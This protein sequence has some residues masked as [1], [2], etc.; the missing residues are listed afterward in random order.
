M[1]FV[2]LRH[3]L[4][5]IIGRLVHHF[6]QVREKS[7]YSEVTALDDELLKFI[8]N[9]PPHYALIPDTSL[10]ETHPFIPIHRF[11]LITEI[12][13]V[14]ISLH[15][16]YLLKRLNSERFSR[17]RVAC[18]ESAL[19]DYEIRQAFKISVPK[20][21]RDS[22]S[23]AYREF[24]TAMISGFYFILEPKGRYSDRMHAILDGF[25][26][27]HEGMHELDE[28]TRRELKTIEFLRAKASEVESLVE[29]R[30]PVPMDSG[31]PEHQ[32]QLLLGFQ[33]STS[34]AKVYSPLFNIGASESTP[35]SP[36]ILAPCQHT[37]Q[38]PTFQRLQAQDHANSPTNSSSP[39]AEEENAAQSLLNHWVEAISNA[40][41]DAPNEAPWV[42]PGGDFPP[43]MAGAN[44]TATPDLRLLTGL[45]GSDWS[46]WETLVSQIPRGQ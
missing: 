28:T 41:V 19:K 29:S 16:P 1:T 5:S 36:S 11:L 34:P 4:A 12:I 15:R 39:Q 24:Q 14:R 37:A 32:V 45:D 13:F 21:T 20:E 10:D 38:S 25:V 33:K 18:F 35:R 27:D 2:I 3:H 17:S 30:R 31:K 26:K 8:E 9:L 42:V 40:P 44:T 23:N 6:Q 46:Y 7:H 43:W 22:L